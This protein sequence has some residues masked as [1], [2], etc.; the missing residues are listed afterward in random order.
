MSFDPPFIIADP[1]IKPINEQNDGKQILGVLV[2][3]DGVNAYKGGRLNVKLLEK[4]V[5][6]K[7]SRLMPKLKEDRSDKDSMISETANKTEN[8]PSSQVIED[9]KDQVE[10][11]PKIFETKVEPTLFF[12]NKNS[13]PFVKTVTAFSLFFIIFPRF[14]LISPISIPIFSKFFAL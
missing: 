12:L 14:N 9:Q 13:I 5:Q 4:I 1:E 6:P 10:E 11:N 8:K 2:V 7:I 3:S